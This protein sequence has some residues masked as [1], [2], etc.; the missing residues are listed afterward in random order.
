MGEYVAIFK[1]KYAS[2]PVEVEELNNWR[3][4]VQR[5]PPESLKTCVDPELLDSLVLS[6]KIPDVS[7]TGAL[8]NDQLKIW[9][10]STVRAS[11]KDTCLKWKPLY[12]ASTWR[13]AVQI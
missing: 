11:H 2:Y 6:K 5:I 4:A 1:G 7:S 3:S 13:K 8:T 12:H 10:E 9:M